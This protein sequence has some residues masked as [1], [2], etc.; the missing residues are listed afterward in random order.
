M[1]RKYSLIY[2]DTLEKPGIFASW[3]KQ[4]SYHA[5]Q[6]TKRNKT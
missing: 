1:Y 2:F 6:R 5:V 4:L 3:K